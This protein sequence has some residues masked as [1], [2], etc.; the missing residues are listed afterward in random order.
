MTKQCRECGAHLELISFPVNARNKDGRDVRCKPC[1]AAKTRKWR[2]ANPMSARA[3]EKR[4]LKN[5][6]ERAKANR[7]AAAKR[8]GK[9]HPD[10]VLFYAKRWKERNPDRVKEQ[11]REW[12]KNNPEKCARKSSERRAATFRAIPP[13][14]SA[15]DRALIAEKFAESKR[16]TKET[17]IKH[18]VDHIIP[19]KGRTV[20]GLHVPWNLQVIPFVDNV[21]KWIHYEANQQ[22]ATNAQN[23]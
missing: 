17:G 18:S 3:S 20:S 13:W 6:P 4:W 7:R 22:G 12:S 16:I 11:S 5:N 10:L 21:R 1:C 23:T 15:E 2:S 19:L 14:L 8:F 9:A